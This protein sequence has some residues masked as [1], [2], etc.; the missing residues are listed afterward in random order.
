MCRWIFLTY[1]QICSGYIGFSR[2]QFDVNINGKTVTFLS[3]KEREKVFLANMA[4]SFNKKKNITSIFSPDISPEFL[5]E[6]ESSIHFE[7]E[8]ICYVLDSNT[9]N[10]FKPIATICAHIIIRS[11]FENPVIARV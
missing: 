4:E 7:N 11:E 6:F 8:R 9:I 1:P 3:N 5:K 10:M 2:K